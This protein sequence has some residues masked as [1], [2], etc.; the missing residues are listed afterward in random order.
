L[1]CPPCPAPQP[2]GWGWA[3]LACLGLALLAAGCGGGGSGDNSVVTAFP[4]SGLAP[5]S[6]LAHVCTLEGEQRFS[7]SYLDEAYLWWHRV[8]EVDPADHGT[9][10]DYFRALLLREPDAAG[11][12]TDRFS[13]VL[14]ASA[15]DTMLSATGDPAATVLASGTETVPL[16]SSVSSEAGRKVGYVLFNRHGRG[17]QDALIQGFEA[18]RSAGVQDLVL[19]LRNNP[20]GYLY[21]AQT[22]ASLVAG[23]QHAG[24]VFE[25]LRYNAKRPAQPS[26]T[27]RFTSTAPRG[28]TVYPAD[29]PLPQLDLPRVYVLAS[30]MTCSASESVVNGLRGVG[31]EVVLV[32][33][34][35]CGKPYG[36]HRKNNCGKAY[37]AIEFQGHNAVGFGDY[38]AGFAPQCPVQENPLASLGSRDEPLLAAALHHIDNGSCPVQARSGAITPARS[39][40]PA[41]G[42]FGR[43]LTPP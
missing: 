14:S 3:R 39:A 7:R 18:L 24:Q 17:A 38:A 19:D 43:L 11:R 32:G 5:S 8:S 15:A 26:G 20:G 22:L 12:P 29:H 21:V 6:T 27:L 35:T 9:V 36:F 41:A 1:P 37:F 28:E 34:T 16:V 25:E 23:P 31:V 4:A 10:Q 2:S 40:D 13:T 42:L 33:A 30:G